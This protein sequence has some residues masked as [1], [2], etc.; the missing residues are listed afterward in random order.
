MNQQ[1]LQLYG[2]IDAAQEQQR[3]V[4]AMVAALEIQQGEL[5]RTVAKANGAVT[6]MGNAGVAA[7]RLIEAAADAATSRGVTTAL[8]GVSATAVQSLSKAA[9]PIWQRFD[10]VAGD[11]EAAERVLRGAMAWF[12]WRWA[13][14]CAVI[15]GATLL[16][17]WMLAMFLMPSWSEIQALRSERAELQTNI[18]AL[19]KR[20]G[21]INT[22]DCGGRL[23]VQVSRDQGKGTWHTTD[24][25][26]TPLIIVDGY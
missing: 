10:Q 5:A 15:A 2:L 1:D 3:V 8:E 21:R 25:K 22:A 26:N 16:T 23:C 6:D 12:T 9:K 24:G 17:M 11:A 14:V 19:A 18:E 7:A 20:G 13:A 4:A